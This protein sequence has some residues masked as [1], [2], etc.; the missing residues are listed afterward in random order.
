MNNYFTNNWH[1][2][3]QNEIKIIKRLDRRR[4]FTRTKNVFLFMFLII[5]LIYLATFASFSYKESAKNENI[6]TLLVLTAIILGVIIIFFTVYKLL[7]KH[8]YGKK[9]VIEEVNENVKF[10]YH[11]MIS[12]VE[13]NDK[14]YAIVVETNGEQM[15]LLVDQKDYE[16]IN[17]DTKLLIGR[18]NDG[19]GY[20]YFIY[21]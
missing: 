13:D 16:L 20:K 1:T 14:L 10:L 4:F 9:S 7:Y 15:E 6:L 11:H 3:S 8:F 17:E 5:V 12:G 2:P 21:Y 19:V 18:F